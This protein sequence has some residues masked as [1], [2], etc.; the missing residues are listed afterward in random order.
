M[1]IVIHLWFWLFNQHFSQRRSKSFSYF[2][3]STLLALV[4]SLHKYPMLAYLCCTC[5][6]RLNSH[7]S[8][9]VYNLA[10][11]CDKH[12]TACVLSSVTKTPR[13]RKT[14]CNNSAIPSLSS[15]NS[16]SLSLAKAPTK[17]FSFFLDKLNFSLTA[18]TSSR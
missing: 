10:V 4:F 6:H 3:P 14:S 16:P 13:Q 15:A 11:K 17:A 2:C 8:P 12:P 18:P 9:I 1:L 5:C 7:S